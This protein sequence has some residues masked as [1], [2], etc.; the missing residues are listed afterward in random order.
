MSTQI[1]VRLTVDLT[2][3]HPGLTAGVEGYTI[4]QYGEWSRGFDRFV[5]VCFPGIHTLDVLWE[6]LEI[7][8]KEYLERVAKERQEK[9]ELLKRAY[10]VVKRVGPRGGFRFLHYEYADKEGRKINES[11]A[12]KAEAEE[13]E[14]FFTEN[15]IPVKIEVE[16]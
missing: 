7:I 2:Q 14:S 3:Y 1:K 11:L 12:F 10:N 13:L 15:G 9:L 4:G 5:G 8:D 16:R 6:S